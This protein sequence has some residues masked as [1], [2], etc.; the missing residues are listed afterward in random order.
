MEN[1]MTS[2]I[3]RKILAEERAAM[4]NQTDRGRPANGNQLYHVL[5]H[6]RLETNRCNEFLLLI[7]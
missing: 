2:A 3:W 5:I 4:V 6:L 1:D 7:R